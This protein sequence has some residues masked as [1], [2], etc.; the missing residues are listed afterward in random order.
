MDPTI[1]PTTDPTADPT[2][3]P[4]A[5]PSSDPTMDPTS[6]PTTEPSSIP[7]IDPTV[8]PTFSPLIAPTNSPSISPTLAP[9]LAPSAAPSLAPTSSPSL[10][11]S[12]SPSLAPSI[13]PSISP[14]LA[15]TVAPSWSPTPTCHFAKFKGRM[16]SKR[17]DFLWGGESFTS[18]NCQFLLRLER[19]GN[20]RLYGLLEGY[21]DPYKKPR[22]GGRRLID[23]DEH[24][25]TW[26]EGWQTNTTLYNYSGQSVPK[27]YIDDGKMIIMEYLYQ[28]AESLKPIEIWS[29]EIISN[30]DL[31]SEQDTVLTLNNRACLSLN[32][33]DLWQH[34]SVFS[35]PDDYNYEEFDNDTF[36]V[37]SQESDDENENEALVGNTL[38]NAGDLKGNSWWIWLLVAVLILLGMVTCFGIKRYF[39]G[40]NVERW[41]EP[42]KRDIE[43]ELEGIDETEGRV[44][45][46]KSA[47]DNTGHVT[48]ESRSSGNGNTS[49]KNYE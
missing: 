13:A 6:D 31:E 20:L 10:A 17:G 38:N 9:S 8:A 47:N 23:E 48:M 30:G 42:S 14:S 1:N 41:S 40:N 16:S 29:S 25:Q 18:D 2:E 37:D 12:R 46:T 3:D 44:N 28:Y 24:P 32:N 4:S 39:C 43:K 33:G 36:V 11:P 19:N 34:C 15:P 22:G 26:Y 49:N 35:A 7:S 27:F 45:E 5:D 21:F